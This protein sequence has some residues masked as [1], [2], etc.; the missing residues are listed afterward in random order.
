MERII[1]KLCL[2]INIMCIVMNDWILLHLLQNVSFCISYY[3]L[4]ILWQAHSVVLDRL[5][6]SH[7]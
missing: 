5:L 7:I 6:I 3:K 2:F 1:I 4:I